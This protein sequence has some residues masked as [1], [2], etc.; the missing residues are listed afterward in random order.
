[1]LR[2]SLDGSS[3][4]RGATLAPPLVG[5]VLRAEKR[6]GT[7]LL[8]FETWRSLDTLALHARAAA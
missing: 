1:M 5:A 6:G 2:R 8:D 4:A 7:D 3:D